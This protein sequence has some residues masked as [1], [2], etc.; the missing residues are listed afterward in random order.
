MAWRNGLLRKSDMSMRGNCKCNN[1]EVV[2]RTVDFSLVPRACQCE[3][4]LA[5]GAAYVGKSGTAVEVLVH[6]ERLHR[7]IEHGSG[8]ARFHECA[9]C[10]DVVF[11]TADIDG[12]VYGVLNAL[13]MKNTLGF[14]S[15]VK[16]DFRGYSAEQKRERWRQNWCYPVTI[17][18]SRSEMPAAPQSV[19][20]GT[21]EG[22]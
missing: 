14:P 17:I 22:T 18:H 20:S 10:G 19:T 3:Y 12:E 4:C 15:Q 21:R 5:K 2:W 13:C 7:V 9:N 16:T 6:K 11:V 1:I 8:S